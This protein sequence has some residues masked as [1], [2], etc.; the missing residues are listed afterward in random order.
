MK[1]DFDRFR[2]LKRVRSLVRMLHSAPARPFGGFTMRKPSALPNSV[3]ILLA[4]AGC[5]APSPEF[6]EPTS[7]SSEELAPGTWK[8]H[9]LAENCSDFCGGSCACITDRCTSNPTGKPCFSLNDTCN[10]V[11][12]SRSQPFVCDSPGQAMLSVVV[13]G[14]GRV[15]RKNGSGIYCYGSGIRRSSD[16]PNDC[17]QYY[18]LNSQVTLEA[19]EDYNAFFSHW[20]PSCG[21]AGSYPNE[22]IASMN[23][24]KTCTA[25][26][27][28]L[29][30]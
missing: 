19:G 26:F 2:R 8:R 6:D 24:D 17:S 22:V 11:H 5:G 9:G 29:G 10:Y 18:T 13:S 28:Y 21:T 14:P 3:L 1:G 20:D 23:A 12:G 15:R 30:N 16:P 4:L 27:E 7:S 25:Y